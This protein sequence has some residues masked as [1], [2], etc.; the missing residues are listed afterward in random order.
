VAREGLGTDLEQYFV[1]AETI[2]DK[3]ETEDYDITIVIGT[4]E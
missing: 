3:S 2:V 4:G 1:D